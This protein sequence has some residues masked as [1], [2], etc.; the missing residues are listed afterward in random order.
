MC[1]ACGAAVPL[2]REVR[3]PDHFGGGLVADGTMR[4]M[5]LRDSETIRQC[6]RCCYLESIERLLIR[7]AD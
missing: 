3:K 7:I 6:V 2:T 5:E 1:D 4:G